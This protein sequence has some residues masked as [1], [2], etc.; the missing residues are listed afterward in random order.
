MKKVENGRF[1]KLDYTGTL[2]NGD[3]FDSSRNAHPIEVEV[4]AGRVI[5]G[6]EDA[7][8]GMA[9]KEKKTFT[10]SPE[11]AYGPRNESME[12]SFMRSE[13]P[14]GFD[15]QVG[16]VLALRN[17]QGGQLPAKV[18]HADEEKI[19]VDLNHPMAG[20]TLTFEVEVLEINDA[21][22]PSS[23]TPSTCSSCGTT[24]S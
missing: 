24:C 7:L 21:P 3:V 5:K 18:K 9:E 23:C 12:Q 19:T 2:K 11:E 8:L 4:G 6:F 22:S 13:L 17:P 1:V 10:L 20:K 15:P 14:Q 16:Q